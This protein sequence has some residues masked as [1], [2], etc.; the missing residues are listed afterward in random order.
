LF[1]D[2][3]GVREGGE[4]SA[5]RKPSFLQL[6]GCRSARGSGDAE[7]LLPRMLIRSQFRRKEIPRCK[8]I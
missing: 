8:P 4:S 5:S 2:C 1:T 7:K 3:N 6:L